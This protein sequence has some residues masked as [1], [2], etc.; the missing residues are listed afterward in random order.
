MA[1]SRATPKP[2]RSMQQMR[3][4]VVER[5]MDAELD[6]L[7]RVKRW[8]HGA[9]KIVVMVWQDFFQNLV[10]LQ[11][12]ALAFKTLLS[13]APLLAVLFSILKAFGVHNRMEPALA[14]AL[15]PLGDKG[16]EI[17]VYLIGFVDKM[18]AGALG[19]IGLVTLFVT[20]LSLMGSIEEAFNRIW[21]VRS[22]RTLAR[23]FSD[24]LSAIL[25]GPV[26]VFAAVTITATLQNNTVVGALTSL[27]TLGQALL[28][29]LRLV[30][31][32]TL[33]GAFTFVYIFIPNTRVRIRSAVIGGLVA[34]VLWQTVGWGFAK[35][36]ASSTQYYAIYSSFAILLLF[37]I[38]LHIGWVIVLLGA[39]VA[40]SH[41]HIYFFH[42]DR[43]LLAQ[44]PA[45]REKLAL[46]AL[47]LVGRNFYYGLDPMTVTE[48]STHLQIPAGIVKE[49]L[50]MFADNRLVLPVNDGETYVLGRD[51]ETIGIKDILDCVRNSGKKA[52]APEDRSPEEDEIDELLGAVELSVTKALEGKSLQSLILSL[53][54]PAARE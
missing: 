7:T 41:Q 38:W 11:A 5:V 33:W 27:D 3:D 40:Y 52:K 54:P 30:P 28:F 21:R 31:Y 39:Q 32:L 8:L 36:V 34:A 14:E 50:D 15:A 49:F 43:Q 17:T 24:Y 29:M 53:P 42:G 1:N 13:L 2:K 23:K 16:R 4:R 10:K 6:E 25:V 9:L 19:T 37:L 44:S 46:H 45:G 12:M 35:F 48:L 22:A 51:P 26:L 47:H 18:S 20:V